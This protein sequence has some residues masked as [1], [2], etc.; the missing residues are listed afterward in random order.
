MYLWKP[1][2]FALS[3][4]IRN[5]SASRATSFWACFS[6][7][8]SLQEH[9]PYNDNDYSAGNEA[10]ARILCL[11]PLS[12][13]H[14]KTCRDFPAVKSYFREDQQW[15]Q[16]L[17]LPLIGFCPRNDH[18]WWQTYLHFQL[19][20]AILFKLFFVFFPDFSEFVHR[21]IDGKGQMHISES[22]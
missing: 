6:L 21:F 7:V 5:R 4:E 19:F 15:T 8:S 18:R 9:N 16:D 14:P 20:F 12:Y 1:A 17:L 22:I 11:E 3:K 13:W 10:A 2:A